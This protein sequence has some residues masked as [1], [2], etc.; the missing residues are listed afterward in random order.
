[1]APPQ[2]LR[3]QTSNCSLLLIYRSRKDERLSWPD[4]LTY[5]GWFTHISG[6]QSATGRAQDSESTPAKDRRTTAGPRN[7]GT[8]VGLGPGDI[9]LD[10]DPALPRKGAQQPPTFRSMPIVAKRSPVSA[11]AELLL[12]QRCGMFARVRASV[13][14][15]LTES[16]D[17]AFTLRTHPQHSTHAHFEHVCTAPHH[18]QCER[19]LTLRKQRHHDFVNSVVMCYD[20]VY[21]SDPRMVPA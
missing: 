6:R 18:I 14:I 16:N 9:V 15:E 21:L 5:N 2:Q 19:A 4:W 8:E 20:H 7:G 11:T 17:D 3:Q 1:M 10:G 12:L 13:V